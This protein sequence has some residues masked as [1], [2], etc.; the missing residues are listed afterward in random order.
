MSD[1][2]ARGAAYLAEKM[3]ESATHS[4]TYSRGSVSASILAG[5]GR[6][7][8]RVQEDDVWLRIESRDFL[9]DPNDIATLELPEEGDEITE[10]IG[11]A[12]VVY[13]VMAPGG[14]PCW[15]WSGPTR[16][17]MRIH[18]RRTSEQA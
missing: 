8:F 10:I 13:E 5:V 9:I 2:M 1:L 7:A 4:V 12:S 6:T 3:A 15:R 16:D 18:T 17:R 14:E 11:G